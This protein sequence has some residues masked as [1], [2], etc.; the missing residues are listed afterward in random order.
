M[1]QTDVVMPE[2]V[3]SIFQYHAV[4]VNLTCGVSTFIFRCF[5]KVIVLHV[6]QTGMCSST[7]VGDFRC[8]GAHSLQVPLCNDPRIARI[9]LI[10]FSMSPFFI[11]AK[12][13]NCST[14]YWCRLL[15]RFCLLLHITTT[16]RG[17]WCV[18]HGEVVECHADG[19]ICSQPSRLGLSFQ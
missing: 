9:G 2:I 12:L 6:Y 10:S 11:H 16:N 17:L 3:V 1:C 14:R 18:L 4:A 13:C 8:R 15:Q 5:S 7:K 19:T